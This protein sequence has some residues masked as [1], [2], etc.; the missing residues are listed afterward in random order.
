[1]AALVWDEIGKHFYETG[2]SKGVLYK[3][4][5]YGVAW[6]GLTSIEESTSSSVESIHFDGLKINDLITIG[7]FT[8]VLRAFTY[9][10]EF[11]AYEGIL[12][13]QTGFY[14]TDQPQSRFG[15]SYQT[16]VGDDIHGVE[17][18]YK[19]H[20][21]YNLTAIP[22]QK[23][24]QTLSEDSSIIEFE[25]SIR[26]VPEYIENFRPTAHVIFDSRKLDPY[27]LEDLE[28]IF[29]GDENKEPR[30][31]SLKGLATFIRK[32]DRLII[33]DNGD[34]TWTAFSPLEDVIIMIDE[35]TF[36]IVSDTAVYLD[37]DTYTI[38]SSEK[39]EEDIWL[40]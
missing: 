40:P 13:D 28:S 8:A 4:D 24:Y 1:M 17:G 34:G 27:L 37:P 33:T 16:N 11:L 6:N 5:T 26:A 35:T 18:G 3:D 30:L 15:L 29:Y 21:L 39:N 12:Q 23:L 7:D 32:W 38:E 2:I 36:Q 22:A 20:L 9:P 19:I 10:D 14:V 31:P 25:W